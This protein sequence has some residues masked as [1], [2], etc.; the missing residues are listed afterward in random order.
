M[1][2][3]EDY[4]EN[5][6]EDPEDE[7]S[8]DDSGIAEDITVNDK[9][10]LNGEI[11]PSNELAHLRKRITEMEK[12]NEQLKARLKVCEYAGKFFQ[13]EFCWLTNKAPPL[14]QHIGKNVHFQ[15]NTKVLNETNIPIMDIKDKWLSEATYP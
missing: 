12:E 5:F 1:I 6:N 11:D 4:D 3:L 15:A 14:T 7:P 8:L 9:E 13:L 10:S 2:T